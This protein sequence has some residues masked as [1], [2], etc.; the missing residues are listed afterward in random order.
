M[1]SQGVLGNLRVYLIHPPKLCA[2]LVSSTGVP[3]VERE[4]RPG[5]G[6]ERPGSAARLEAPAGLGVRGWSASFPGAAYS[7]Q[8]AKWDL[9]IV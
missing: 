5:G 4:R 3:G 6:T 8:L 1:I 2:R 7:V 9:G